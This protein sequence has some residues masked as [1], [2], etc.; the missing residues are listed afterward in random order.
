MT[1]PPPQQRTDIDVNEFATLLM[2]E[3][4]RIRRVERKQHDEM[5]EEA[6]DFA[7]NEL[8]RNNNPGEAENED[9]AVA[10]AERERDILLDENEKLLLNQI[11]YAFERMNKG[12]YGICEVTGQPIPVERL[13][14]LPW[15]TTV[16]EAVTELD[17]RERIA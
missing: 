12:L 7:D 14:A 15:T 13:R 4:N 10:I 6:K 16:I 1:V 5:L 3:R 11:D 8:S 17:S 2:N 9:G